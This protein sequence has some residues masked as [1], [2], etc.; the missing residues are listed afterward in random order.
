M[1]RY[2]GANLG[3]AAI[4]EAGNF[5]QV[6]MVQAVGS[7]TE[8]LQI[9][10]FK[11]GYTAVV[12]YNG[13][14][15]EARI[16]NRYITDP[17]F[18]QIWSPETRY[19]LYLPAAPP[20]FWSIPVA[21]GGSTYEETLTLART[22]AVTEATILL[23]NDNLTLTHSLSVSEDTAYE[24]TLTLA[25]SNAV[26]EATALTANDNLALAHSLSISEIGTLQ[27]NW[28]VTLSLGLAITTGNDSEETGG[29]PLGD[30]LIN[31]P[32]I[33]KANKTNLGY[34]YLGNAG[35]NTVSSSTGI[36]LAA[37]DE[38]IFKWVGN[39][40]SIIMASSLEGEGVSWIRLK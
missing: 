6:S 18:W 10:H 12:C 23:A 38:V 5:S 20:R 7:T 3:L 8:D 19:D 26:T 33:V 25:R 30:K 9:G 28:A 32:L 34:V 29:L 39:V 35:D 4:N 36:I 31:G 24:E 21:G 16:Y 1:V 13:P 17:E 14:I 15:A 27:T 22:G 37:G 2:D 40:K 11:E